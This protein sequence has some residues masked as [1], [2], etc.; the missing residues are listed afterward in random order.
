MSATI[1]LQDPQTGALVHMRRAE[2]SQTCR[3]C[4]LKMLGEWIASVE[5]SPWMCI[6]HL[7]RTLMAEP[8]SREFKAK[9]EARKQL[10]DCAPGDEVTVTRQ[11][12]VA[13]GLV[14]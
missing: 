8:V 12:M 9:A 14:R 10:E 6:A 7:E 13:V 2:L 5:G 4:G 3:A 1:S 11:M